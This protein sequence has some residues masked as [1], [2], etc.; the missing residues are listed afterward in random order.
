MLRLLKRS[1][2]IDSSRSR[3]SLS[4]CSC[5]RSRNDDSSPGV[6]DNASGDGTASPVPPAAAELAEGMPS[7][8]DRAGRDSEGN[9]DDDSAAA[10]R[11]DTDADADEPE[12]CA[13]SGEFASEPAKD[14]EPDDAERKDG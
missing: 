3:C 7:V 6:V 8:E 2:A 4:R 12:S 14:P 1:I 13:M 10:G 9:A 11:D 5:S